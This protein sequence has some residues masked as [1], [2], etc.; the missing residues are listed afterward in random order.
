MTAINPFDHCDEI[1]ALKRGDYVMLTG[2]A[3][4]ACA[5]RESG[6]ET[7]PVPGHTAMRVLLASDD[8][9]YSKCLIVEV[10]WQNGGTVVCHVWQ[11]QF[12]LLEVPA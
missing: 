9:F 11:S 6:W 10:P 5:P 12:G 8:G 1:M 7:V 3:D 4:L 2:P